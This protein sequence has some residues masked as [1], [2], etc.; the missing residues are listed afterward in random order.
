MLALKAPRYG[1]MR[2]GVLDDMALITGGRYVRKDAGDAIS[3]VTVEDLGRAQT[4]VCNRATFTIIGTMGR[5]QAIRERIQ[6]LRRTRENLDEKEDR[7]NIDE[8]IGKLLG[9]TAI[10]HVS[11]QSKE[12]RDRRK[13]V[14]KIAVR[15]VRQGLLDGI[16]PGGGAAYASVL[17]ALD[18]VPLGEEEA[19]AREMMRQ[20]LL[21]P[22]TCLVRNAGYDP[23]PAI[24]RVQDAPEG[25]G[26]DVSQG[27]FVDMMAANV[28][29][30]LSTV[31][32]AFANALSVAAMALTTDV[33]IHRDPGKG[34]PNLN[35]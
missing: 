24:A 30:P 9:G 13:E 16:V 4:V 7:D 31:R 17:P 1:D 2:T 19:P 29:D 15:V 21:A 32:A 23:G 3:R 10:L 5:P 35:P 33:L 12:D 22:M 18:D 8:R 14:G 20:A 26:F 6:E 34:V 27:K 11:S 28:V 25:W